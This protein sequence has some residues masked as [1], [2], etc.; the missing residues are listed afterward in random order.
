MRTHSKYKTK[1]K[2][3]LYPVDLVYFWQTKHLSE[4]VCL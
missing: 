2:N 1:Q 4:Q 3:E